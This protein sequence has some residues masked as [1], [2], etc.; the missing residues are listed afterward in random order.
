[1]NVSIYSIKVGKSSIDKLEFN[2]E[3]DFDSSCAT[4][5]NPTYT[6]E[7]ENIVEHDTANILLDIYDVLLAGVEAND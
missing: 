7:S 6:E 3:L 2:G 5:D 4:K 1:M